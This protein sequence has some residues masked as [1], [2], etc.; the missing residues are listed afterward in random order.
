MVEQTGK[1]TGACSLKGSMATRSPSSA[2]SLQAFTFLNVSKSPTQLPKMEYSGAILAHCNLRLPGSSHSPVPA[3][4]VAGITGDRHHAWLSILLLVERGF[5]HVGQAG[6]ELLTSGNQPASASQ[7]AGITGVSHHGSLNNHFLKTDRV[8]LCCPVVVQWL[9]LSSLQ[10]PPPSSSDSPASGSR[11]HGFTMF[12]QDGLGLLT[13]RPTCPSLQSAEITG[14]FLQAIEPATNQVD[15]IGPENTTLMDPKFIAV[16]REPPGQGPRASTTVFRAVAPLKPGVCSQAPLLLLL[17]LLLLLFLL[18]SVRLGAIRSTFVPYLNFALHFCGPLRRWILRESGCI[19]LGIKRSKEVTHVPTANQVPHNRRLCHNR[20]LQ[21]KRRGRERLAFS[22]ASILNSNTPTFRRT[23]LQ[24]EYIIKKGSVLC[25]ETAA[26]LDSS[27][28]PPA[29]AVLQQLLPEQNR[30]SSLYTP[31]V[32]VGTSVSYNAAENSNLRLG[33]HKHEPEYLRDKQRPGFLSWEKREHVKN[34]GWP[35]LKRS[36][37]DSCDDDLPLGL[38]S[39]QETSSIFLR[40]HD[41]EKGTDPS[42]PPDHQ[43]CQE[44]AASALWLGK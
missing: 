10:P 3:S 14:R 9:D 38:C 21:H 29:C 43:L 11:T 2:T 19:I 31:L 33:P 28:A 36:C 34:S 27:V 12:G 1:A 25:Q 26:A 15:S 41:T 8:L 16:K 35:S 6:L 44:P 24:R 17:L 4:R 42:C 37:V 5:H 20:S 22:A 18:L 13:S 39:A 7:S 30:C 40:S 23:T 32:A